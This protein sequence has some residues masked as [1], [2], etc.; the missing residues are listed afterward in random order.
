MELQ[1]LIDP[2]NIQIPEMAG[3]KTNLITYPPPSVSTPILNHPNPA[4]EQ[5]IS[6]IPTNPQ[7]SSVIPTPASSTTTAVTTTQPSANKVE[8]K[9]QSSQNSQQS[10]AAQQSTPK[11]AE[12]QATK[13]PAAENSDKKG[14]NQPTKDI[15]KKS[16]TQAAN[17]SQ[18]VF[19]GAVS[20]FS[21][22]WYFDVI[23]Q[24]WIS[25]VMQSADV[26]SPVSGIPSASATSSGMGSTAVAMHSA[27]QDYF[28]K[29]SLEA[30]KKWNYIMVNSLLK[31][32]FKF[33]LKKRKMRE[34]EFQ[35]KIKEIMKRKQ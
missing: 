34:I 28:N 11:P 3:N 23:F 19:A 6:I 22:L 13:D 9:P 14:K 17:L 8:E 7:K 12:Q 27:G 33:Y 16:K 25:E 4:P 1:K 15:K 30:K 21:I 18:W 10:P 35:E 20:G 24:K 5:K 32:L 26:L 29:F 31:S 2:I